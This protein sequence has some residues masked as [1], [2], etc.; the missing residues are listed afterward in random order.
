[1]RQI[2]LNLDCCVPSPPFDLGGY[3]R[4]PTAWVALHC[5]ERPAEALEGQAG[6]P[7][8][9]KA[10]RGLALTA[11][12]RVLPWVTLRRR[13]SISRRPPAQCAASSWKAR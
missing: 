11:G 7:I 5:G 8:F 1:M 9:R 12:R 6:A 10:G 2:V 3:A 4:L 13:C